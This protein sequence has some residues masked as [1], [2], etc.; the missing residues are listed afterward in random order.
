MLGFISPK[1]G[2]APGKAPVFSCKDIFNACA[3]II[4]SCEAL[5][6]IF[7]SD[8]KYFKAKS[9]LCLKEACSAFQK[10]K[11][12]DWENYVGPDFKNKR[13]LC[14]NDFLVAA[15][16]ATRTDKYHLVMAEKIPEPIAA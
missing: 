4:A 14:L 1:R 7:I 15:G 9:G 11:V 2:Y 16:F 3:E 5:P 6:D 10:D 12:K 8:P 13:P